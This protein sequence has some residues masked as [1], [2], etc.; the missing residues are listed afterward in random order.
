MV[1]GQWLPTDAD[2]RRWWLLGLSGLAGFFASDL[3][4]FRSLLLI[5]PRLTLLVQ[6]LAPPSAAILSWVFLARP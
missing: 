2:R 3:C 5:G 1:R 4:A 6:S